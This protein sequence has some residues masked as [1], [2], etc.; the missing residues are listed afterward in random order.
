MERC[1]TALGCHRSN[2]R[3]FNDRPDI[4][5]SVRNLFLPLTAPPPPADD[6]LASAA[7]PNDT[8]DARSD[9]CTITM[10]Y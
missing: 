7:S 8:P 4:C 3:S 6:V 9:T 5:E 1:L 2:S 10:T